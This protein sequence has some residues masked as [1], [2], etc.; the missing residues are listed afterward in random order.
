ME[1]TG[2][3]WIPTYDI[4]EQR[5]FKVV[6][7]NARHVKNVPGRKTDVVDCQWIQELHEVGLLRGSFRPSAEIVSLRAYLRHRE[8]L[9]QEAAN[10]IRR[11]QKSLVLMNVHLH[12]VITDITGLTGMQIVRDIASGVTDPNAL[13]SHRHSRCRASEEEIAAALTGNY[14]REQVFV[15]RQNLELYDSY[16]RQIGTCDGEIESLLQGRGRQARPSRD[17]AATG[18]PPAAAQ[19]RPALRNPQPV[20]RPFP[21]RAARGPHPSKIGEVGF[22]R[23]RQGRG[24]VGHCVCCRM[25]R[26]APAGAPLTR[27]TRKAEAHRVSQACAN[28][29]SRAGSRTLRDAQ[30]SASIICGCAYS[31]NPRSATEPSGRNNRIGSSRR[32]MN[33]NPS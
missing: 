33:P 8:T 15:L 6:L 22:A 30:R 29:S 20:T 3:Y 2:V 18:A 12:N 32:G 23:S 27:F 4:L 9:V 21:G 31:L 14:R 26:T 17:S 11:M 16:Q 25:E 5:G 28:M 24:D 13:A 1:A 7:V 19:E 10:H